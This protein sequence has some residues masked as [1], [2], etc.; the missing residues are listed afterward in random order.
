MLW[1]PAPDIGNL[2]AALPIALL[3]Y[4]C[5]IV[6]DKDGP[7]GASW[8]ARPMGGNTTKMA[9]SAEE[10]RLSYPQRVFS[11]DEAGIPKK[12]D[13]GLMSTC[14]HPA[15]EHWDPDFVR[16][17]VG[18]PDRNRLSAQKSRTAS[19]TLQVIRRREGWDY[20]AL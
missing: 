8:P 17:L 10:M 1:G 20:G 6:P 12:A 7:T 5:Q 16:I 18:R 9:E 4:T 2:R 13:A 11:T 14:Y 3:S 15:H 19:A